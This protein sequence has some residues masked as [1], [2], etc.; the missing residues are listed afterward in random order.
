VP[1]LEFY[2]CFHFFRTAA[3]LH[4]I[5]GRVRAG[6]AAG[7]GALELAATARPL[8]QMALQFA[9]KLGA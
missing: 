4:G 8:S 9:A 1:R 3:I 7:E 5:A 6:T 2:L